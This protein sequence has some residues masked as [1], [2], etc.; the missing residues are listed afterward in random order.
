MPSQ[1]SVGPEEGVDIAV[2]DFRLNNKSGA[3]VKRGEIVQLGITTSEA[4]GRLD[5]FIVVTT[6]GALGD[7]M[8]CV[9]ETIGRDKHGMVRI[10]GRVKHC[11]FGGTIAKGG[12]GVANVGG[13]DAIPVTGATKRKIILKSEEQGT[14]GTKR[15]VI[16]DGWAGFGKDEI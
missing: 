14:S 11:N 15:A 9:L 16:F 7:I 4:T 5:A 13:G 3:T 8:G 10:Q 12:L 2:L 6:A 1:N